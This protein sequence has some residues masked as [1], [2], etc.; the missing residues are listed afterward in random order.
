MFSKNYKILKFSIQ[1]K[2]KLTSVKKF[3]SPKSLIGPCKLAGPSRNGPLI[4]VTVPVYLQR[5]IIA[6]FSVFKL[7]LSVSSPG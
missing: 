1:S 6:I 7:L 2:Q 3:F 5:L 4:T